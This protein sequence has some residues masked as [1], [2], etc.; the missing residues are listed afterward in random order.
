MPSEETVRFCSLE[1]GLGQ[2][3]YARNQTGIVILV[4]QSILSRLHLTGP[5]PS[6]GV[7]LSARLSEVVILM[8][9]VSKTA[10]NARE[11][12]CLQGLLV[13]WLSFLFLVITNQVVLMVLLV[14]TATVMIALLFIVIT[15]LIGVVAASS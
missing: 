6:F 10:V 2:L 5:R 7:V 9:I 11:K 1:V 8:L 13:R 3:Q 15:S 14:A 12:F 4:L